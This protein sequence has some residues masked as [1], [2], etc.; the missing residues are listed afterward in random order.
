MWSTFKF[1]L[2]V[3]KGGIVYSVNPPYHPMY[4]TNPRLPLQHLRYSLTSKSACLYDSVGSLR[5]LT[6]S[7]PRDA[8][9]LSYPIYHYILQTV[10]HAFQLWRQTEKSWS[11][12]RGATYTIGD[13]MNSYGDWTFS[14]FCLREERE[15][16]CWPVTALPPLPS[17][18]SL[19]S[20]LPSLPFSHFPTLLC[21]FS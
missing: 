19:L 12:P 5:E 10:V 9:P 15:R 20:T 17:L 6:D 21:Y 4:T 16:E 18:P 1:S 8:L 7:N 3:E 11:G 13:C 2:I 14:H